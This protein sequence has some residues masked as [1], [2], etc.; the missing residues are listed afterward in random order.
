MFSPTTADV[1]FDGLIVFGELANVSE[2]LVDVSDVT[3]KRTSSPYS[4][5]IL[6]VTD[7]T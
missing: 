6:V 4:S 5:F 2:T 3:G 1:L 7:L